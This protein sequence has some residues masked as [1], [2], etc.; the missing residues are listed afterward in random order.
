[1]DIMKFPSNS[2]WDQ[3][4][5]FQK[6]VML[7]EMEFMNFYQNTNSHFNIHKLRIFNTNKVKILLKL[8]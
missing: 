6:I 7:K 4:F 2:Q 8:F 3:D 5:T 1:M